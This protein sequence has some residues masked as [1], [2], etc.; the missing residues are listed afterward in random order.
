MHI[1]KYAHTTTKHVKWSDLLSSV[2]IS[3]HHSHSY[4]VQNRHLTPSWDTWVTTVSHCRGLLHWGWSPCPMVV[5][6]RLICDVVLTRSLLRVLRMMQFFS[7]GEDCDCGHVGR[8]MEDY[9]SQAKTSSIY[10]LMSSIIH[11]YSIFWFNLPNTPFHSHG[12]Y[13]FLH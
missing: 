12:K 8:L 3:P 10:R 5:P 13:G 1:N 2:R 7:S 4:E 6:K 11:K 9:I